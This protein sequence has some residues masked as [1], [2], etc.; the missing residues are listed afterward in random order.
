MD[1]RVHNTGQRMTVRRTQA[2]IKML[3]EN[4]FCV[5]LPSTNMMKAP[6]LGQPE[7]KPEIPYFFNNVDRA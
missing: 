6:S 3:H 2:Y 4:C 7:K 5:L 1:I